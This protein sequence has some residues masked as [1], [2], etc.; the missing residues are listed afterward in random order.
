[1]TPKKALE[2]IGNTLTQVFDLPIKQLCREEYKTL[3]KFIKENER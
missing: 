3:E 2:K 1:M